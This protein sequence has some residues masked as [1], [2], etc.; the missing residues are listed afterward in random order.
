[1]KYITS[2]NLFDYAFLNEDSLQKPVKGVCIYFHGYTDGTRYK[3]SPILGQKLGEQGIA[4]VFS[5]HSVWAW[6]SETSQQYCEQVLDAVYERLG[7]DE[8]VPLVV[9][10][11]SMGGMTALNYLIHG[12][13]KAIACAANCPV[14]SVK[15]YFEKSSETRAAIL[16]AHIEKEGELMEILADLSPIYFTEKLPKIPYFFVFGK[17][18]PT[19]AIN[20]HIEELKEK[21]SKNAIH[22]KVEFREEMEHCNMKDFPDTIGRF[23]DFISDVVNKK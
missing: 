18:D 2:D 5:Y 17:K 20:E 10:G 16:S 3:E 1:M 23:I 9:T 13:R 15:G 11:G 7:I 6:M 22:Y 14:L 21:L 19:P 4:W 8:S 12:K